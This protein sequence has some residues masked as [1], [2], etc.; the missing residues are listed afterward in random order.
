MPPV[1]FAAD[2][3]PIFQMS[4]SAVLCHG[5]VL[6]QFFTINYASLVNVPALE[7]GLRVVP[8]NLNASYLWTKLT[9]GPGMIGVQMP[10]AGLPLT[11][12]QLDLISTWILEGAQNN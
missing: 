2:V 8:G 11:P 4:C 6:P 3:Q 7:G 9:S 5:A 1:S 12:V 10:N